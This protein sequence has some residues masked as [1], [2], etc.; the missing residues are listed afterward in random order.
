MLLIELHSFIIGSFRFLFWA[1]NEIPFLAPVLY[2]AK[3]I[4]PVFGQSLLVIGNGIVNLHCCYLHFLHFGSF[5]AFATH[6]C[7]QRHYVFGL[8]V[9]RVSPSVYPSA[10]LSRQI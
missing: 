10:S 2:S 4:K 9:R 3:S 6:Q 1:D 8:F 7:Q 5:Y